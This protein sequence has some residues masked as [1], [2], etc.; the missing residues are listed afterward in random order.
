[1]L[2]GDKLPDRVELLRLNALARHAEG[3]L[4]VGQRI[5]HSSQQRTRL[6][7]IVVEFG[8]VGDG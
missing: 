8:K 6:A 4:A 1:M 2:K 5:G 3:F 7:A